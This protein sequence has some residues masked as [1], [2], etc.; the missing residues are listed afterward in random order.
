M[1]ATETHLFTHGR[2]EKQKMISREIH[3]VN[4]SVVCREPGV[5]SLAT[6]SAV[7][8]FDGGPPLL[9]TLLT[10]ILPDFFVKDKKLSEIIQNEMLCRNKGMKL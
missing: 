2:G 5:W 4:A 6:Q 3:L 8:R 10:L 1:G 9:K 7:Y